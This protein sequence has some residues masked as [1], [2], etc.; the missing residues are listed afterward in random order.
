MTT[1]IA[2]GVGANLLGQ[3]SA[4]RNQDATAYVGNL[5]PHVLSWATIFGFLDLHL[6][7]LVSAMTQIF[8]FESDTQ[9]FATSE[10]SQ[11]LK[12]VKDRRAGIF[13]GLSVGLYPISAVKTKMQRIG[14]VITGEIPARIIFLTALETTKVAAFKMVEPLNFQ[15]LQK[16]LLLMELLE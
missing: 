3:H 16:L 14:T 1:R 12:R 5:D 6:C 7:F 2:P 11:A 15:T 4:K 9:T 10:G 13:T 8:L